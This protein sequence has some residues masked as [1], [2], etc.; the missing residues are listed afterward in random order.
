MAKSALTAILWTGGIATLVIV[1]MHLALGSASI[2][3]AGPVSPTVDGED[4]FYAVIFGGYG[5]ALIYCAKD[6]ATRR[7]T[8]QLL[9]GLFMAG[10][11]ARA[12]SWILV[13]RPH[14]FFI[15]MLALELVLPMVIWALQ[16]KVARDVA[17]DGL[18]QTGEF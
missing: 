5:F 12:V 6:V 11:V 2:P 7:S 13:G 18:P 10:G 17:Q 4:R 15:V 14:R 1:V 8:I 16:K 9:A 3:G